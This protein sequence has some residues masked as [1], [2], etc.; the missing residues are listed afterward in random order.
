M[1]MVVCM[2]CMYVS[3]C[4]C[5]TLCVTVCTRIDVY[6]HKRI[7]MTCNFL[8]PGDLLIAECTDLIAQVEQLYNLVLA[9]PLCK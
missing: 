1:C 9:V 4:L 7:Y 3:A 2:C 6:V 8:P 5:T